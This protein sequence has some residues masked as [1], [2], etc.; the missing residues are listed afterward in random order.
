MQYRLTIF[1]EVKKNLDRTLL[2]VN[3]ISL[4]PEEMFLFSLF[5]E[6]TASA[7]PSPCWTNEIQI[8]FIIIVSYGVS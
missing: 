1:K 4:P 7:I 2:D 5:W 3:D 6:M 8:H